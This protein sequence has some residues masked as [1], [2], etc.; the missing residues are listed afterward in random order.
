MIF[1]KHLI[2]PVDKNCT[3]QQ[4]ITF[5]FFSSYP[6]LL[7]RFVDD[8]Q[9]FKSCNILLYFSYEFVLLVFIKSLILLLLLLNLSFQ[10]RYFIKTFD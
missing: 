2:N 7:S 6:W 3:W 9:Q 5:F 10:E 4:S 1:L 8:P